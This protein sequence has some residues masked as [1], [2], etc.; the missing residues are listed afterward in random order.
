MASSV[1]NQTYFPLL[2]LLDSQ[3]DNQTQNPP[4]TGP[5]R[6]VIF[7]YYMLLQ[8]FVIHS[9]VVLIYISF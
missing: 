9:Y 6:K 4:K 3:S 1:A 2:I 5:W 7:E 8:L